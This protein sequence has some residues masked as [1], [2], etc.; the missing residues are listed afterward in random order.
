[1]TRS[2]WIAA[3][4]AIVLTSLA[5]PDAAAGQRFP[6]GLDLAVAQERLVVVDVAKGSAADSAGFKPGDVLVTIRGGESAWRWFGMFRGAIYNGKSSERVKV[7]RGGKLLSLSVRRGESR[8]WNPK[9]SLKEALKVSAKGYHYVGIGIQMGPWTGDG[10]LIE[11]VVKGSPADDEGLKPGMKVV[12]IDRSSTW[13]RNSGA[14]LIRSLADGKTARVGLA[15]QLKVVKAD[16]R[17]ARFSVTREIVF[18]RFVP[19]PCKFRAARLE[20]FVPDDCAKASVRQ[21]AQHLDRLAAMVAGIRDSCAADPLAKPALAKYDG[22]RSI[23]DARLRLPKHG[24]FVEYVKQALKRAGE[25]QFKTLAKRF[26]ATYPQVALDLKSAAASRDS[27]FAATLTTRFGRLKDQITARR[28]WASVR[29]GLLLRSVSFRQGATPDASF[30]PGKAADAWLK[31]SRD[32]VVVVTDPSMLRFA[33]AGPGYRGRAEV[34][35]AAGTP[36]LLWGAVARRRRFGSVD[37][38]FPTRNMLVVL[39]VDGTRYELPIAGVKNQRRV[40]GYRGLQAGEK[41]V[42]KR[43]AVPA[44]SRRD[45]VG[46]GRLGVIS[47]KLADK[48]AKLDRKAKACEDRRWDGFVDKK[49]RISRQRMRWHT[50]RARIDKLEDATQAA[51]DRH[52]YGA[53]SRSILSKANKV[54]RAKRAKAFKKVKKRVAALR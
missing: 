15:V 49:D 16:G 21:C 52:C 17:V 53:A 35:P 31:A 29:D 4:A 36:L 27:Y 51:I 12:S 43:P 9:A 10:R 25:S 3:T 38:A 24:K 46:L 39:T 37:P 50:K 30:H 19:A 11:R 1:M 47:P 32:M 8:N 44:L 48:Q 26:D 2:S 23:L 6:S 13:L 28:K 20:H 5:A 40:V 45:L 34:A 41:L 42:A 54:Y 14:R 18:D 22:A 7:S 33:P